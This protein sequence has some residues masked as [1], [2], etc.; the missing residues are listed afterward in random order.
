C[1]T[2]FDHGFHGHG[3]AGGSNQVDFRSAKFAPDSA[4]RVAPRLE[5]GSANHRH[6]QQGMKHD[7]V[8]QVTFD[9]EIVRIGDGA[10]HFYLVRARSVRGSVTMLMLLMPDWRKASMTDANAPKGTVSSHRKKTL[11]CVLFNCA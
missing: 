11:R 5:K 10:G 2:F 6:G 9:I 7:R 3:Y 1:L 8:E 4:P